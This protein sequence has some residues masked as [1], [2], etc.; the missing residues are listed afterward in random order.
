MP[1]YLIQIT[2]SAEVGAALVLNPQDHLRL[3][4]PVAE[5]FDG[6]IEGAWAAFGEFDFVAIIQMPHNVGAV[7]F[8]K[9][10]SASGATSSIKTTP[11][12]TLE[13]ERE[14]MEK[15]GTARYRPPARSTKN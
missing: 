3:L 14:A 1:Y 6:T 12:V 10:V 15:A 4:R 11:L 7:A 2:W 13:E 9:V 8:S 5:K